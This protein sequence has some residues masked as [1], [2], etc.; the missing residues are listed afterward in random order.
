MT[1]VFIKLHKE[2]QDH[3]NVQNAAQMHTRNK[4]KSYM[5]ETIL[6]FLSNYCSS[7]SCN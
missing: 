3:F 1:S 7:F 4:K 2:H 6:C 5:K